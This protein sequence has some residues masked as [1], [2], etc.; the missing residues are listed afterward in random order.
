MLYIGYFANITM[1]CSTIAVINGF[2]PELLTIL[3]ENPNPNRWRDLCDEN[4]NEN[5]LQASDPKKGF[6]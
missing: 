4:N 1:K 3:F 2:L 5:T 6:F